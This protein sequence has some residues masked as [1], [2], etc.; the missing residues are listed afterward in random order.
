[1]CFLFDIS[2]TFLFLI[3]LGMEFPE[4][5]NERRKVCIFAPN[6]NPQIPKVLLSDRSTHK[7]VTVSTSD[8]YMYMYVHV[9]HSLW[10]IVS[11][12]YLAFWAILF[13][14]TCTKPSSNSIPFYA[15]HVHYLLILNFSICVPYINV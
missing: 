11:T 10:I 8:N 4:G 6:P 5:L 2:I 1:M 15:V 13:V 7:P 9:A 3:Q 14:V 12:I